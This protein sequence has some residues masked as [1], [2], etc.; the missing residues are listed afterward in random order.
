M[1]ELQEAKEEQGTAADPAA[2]VEAEL[3]RLDAE[4]GRRKLGQKALR[5]L[6]KAGALE[7]L[8]KLE[9]TLGKLERT[10]APEVLADC[11][12]A[13]LLAALREHV[14]GGAQ[15]LRHELGRELKSACEAANLAFEVVSRE[16]PVELRIA[17]LSVRLDFEKGRASLSFAR[18]ELCTAP[19]RAA[20]ILE[21]RAAA[22]RELETPFEPREFF[23]RCWN[24]YRL[25]LT[26]LGRGR[27]ER[28]ELVEFLPQLAL[29]S[30]PKKF[31]VEP[32]A[33]NYEDYSRARFAY[34]VLRLRRANGLELAGKRMHF[35]VATGGTAANKSR[36]LFLEDGDGR[37]EYKL[38]VYFTEG[39]A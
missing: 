21:A 6:A 12:L 17:P 19:A 15:R 13:P 24:A 27:G 4:I 3:R 34:D 5:P 10:L 33:R 37:G 31:Q 20:A 18:Q 7:D 32:I 28:V 30:Q 25:A 35:G 14:R 36:V 16:D 8:R 2:R 1:S 11:R 22:L 39:A 23:E 38:T 26:A 9:A 29:L